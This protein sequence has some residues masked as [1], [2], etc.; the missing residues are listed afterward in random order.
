MLLTNAIALMA[1]IVTQ[2]TSAAIADTTELSIIRGDR[3]SLMATG[4]LTAAD[5][6]HGDCEYSGIIPGVWYEGVSSFFLF[7]W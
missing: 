5:A 3:L 1:L 6:P 7:I 4:P 2:V